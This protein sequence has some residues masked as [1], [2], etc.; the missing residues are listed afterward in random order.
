MM[1][2]HRLKKKSPDAT[3]S[4]FTV[5]ITYEN[6]YGYKLF[7]FSLGT[8]EFMEKTSWYNWTSLEW[9]WENGTG[10]VCKR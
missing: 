8:W 5:Q 2:K 9:S 1:I 4:L 3:A 10:D 6:I 7:L